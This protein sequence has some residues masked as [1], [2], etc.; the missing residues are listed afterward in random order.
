MVPNGV[1]GKPDLCEDWFEGS[2][3]KRPLAMRDLVRDTSSE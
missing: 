3:L 1:Y 2:I